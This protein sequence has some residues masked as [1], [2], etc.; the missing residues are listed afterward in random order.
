MMHGQ[1]NIKKIIQL[2]GFSAYPDGSPY[3][4][5]RIS[6]VP[7][8]IIPLQTTRKENNWKTEETLARTVATLETERIK[9]VQSLMFM[10]MKWCATVFASCSTYLCVYLGGTPLFAPEHSDRR[11]NPWT[12]H[13]TS[14]THTSSQAQTS[15]PTSKSSQTKDGGWFS[16]LGR[17]DKC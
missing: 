4:L 1:K 12:R 5:I 8:E 13:V 10:M 3:Q 2:S 7:V 17:L 14:Q 16:V 11:Q 6:G 15:Q 9:L